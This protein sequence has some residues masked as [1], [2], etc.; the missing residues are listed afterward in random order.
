MF[1]LGIVLR[2]F[3]LIEF[4]VRR[5]L[6]TRHE[7][8]EG[9]YDGAPHKTTDRPTTERLLKA[10]QGIT[11]LRI[12]VGQEVRYQLSGFS[13]LPRRIL[14]LLG[15]PSSLYTALESSP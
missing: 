11:L 1:I 3:T 8:L 10:F 2:A 7:S 5:E 9:L 6:Q 14:Q 13:K 15:L 12:R 4:V